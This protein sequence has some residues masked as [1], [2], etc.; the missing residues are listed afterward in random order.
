MTPFNPDVNSPPISAPGPGPG[1]GASVPPGKLDEQ[2]SKV[3]SGRLAGVKAALNGARHFIGKGIK[4]LFNR[5][6]SSSSVAGQ[7]VDSVRGDSSLKGVPEGF[8]GRLRGGFPE[9]GSW[10]DKD[11]YPSDVFKHLRDAALVIGKL[12]DKEIT[13]SEFCEEI[14]SCQLTGGDRRLLL[15]K[16]SGECREPI[17]QAIIRKLNAEVE[18]EVQSKV[19][20]TKGEASNL[21]AE[22]AEAMPRLSPFIS[23]ASSSEMKPRKMTLDTLNQ[24]LRGGNLFMQARDNALSPAIKALMFTDPGQGTVEEKMAAFK[25]KARENLEEFDDAA[26]EK[27][28]ADLRKAL[29]D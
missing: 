18:A 8:S 11:N 9:K 16:F 27:I 26:Q 2:T 25:E 5:G 28:M 6:S 24:E 17:P 7:A 13:F 20:A 29:E 22:M 10:L 14:A 1:N 19:S 15:T 3:A 23:S 12:I 4:S 21:M